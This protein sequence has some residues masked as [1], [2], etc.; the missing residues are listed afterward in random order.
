MI[1]GNRT[2]AWE[3][4]RS[5]GGGV[6]ASFTTATC[7]DQLRLSPSGPFSLRRLLNFHS[8][9]LFTSPS[10]MECRCDDQKCEG[11]KRWVRTPG[12][13]KRNQRDIIPAPRRAGS[14]TTDWDVVN[15]GETR[16]PKP[17][18]GKDMQVS[19]EWM[20]E[21]RGQPDLGGRSCLSQRPF[22]G[23]DLREVWN[24]QGSRGV[25][26]TPLTVDR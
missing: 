23:L 11:R 13:S 4:P 20:P 6:P 18:S 7:N 16:R 22:D 12:R 8:P 21:V 9:K 19:R 14:T 1:S 17:S 10:R 2:D 3:Q 24:L 25:R 5:P 15:R 26:Q